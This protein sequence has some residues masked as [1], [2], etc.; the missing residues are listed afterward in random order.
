MDYRNVVFIALGSNLGDSIST[1][2]TAMG[3]LQEWTP[4]PLLASSLWRT[5]PVDCPP[6]SPP[7]INAM[8]GLVFDDEWDVLALLGRIKQL[9]SE[10][11]RLPNAQRH[12]PRLLD[13]DF[14]AY[15]VRVC[16]SP[17][18]ILPHPRA[19]TRGFVLAPWNE[20]APDYVAPGQTTSVGELLARLETTETLERLR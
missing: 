10:F 1:V 18:L 2:R 7:F 4:H 3:R 14:I 9:E 12:A 6:G 16:Q 19:H 20:I 11:G 15:G 13:L 8:V 17:A 5:S